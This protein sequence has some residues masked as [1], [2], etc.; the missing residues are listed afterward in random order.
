MSSLEERMQQLKAF[1]IEGSKEGE[2]DDPGLSSGNFEPL[3]FVA[4]FVSGTFYQ[5][6]TDLLDLNSDEHKDLTNTF[7]VRAKGQ[8]GHDYFF[9]D[10][11]A[12][13]EAY[14]RH[15]ALGG[16]TLPQVPRVYAFVFQ[17]DSGLSWSSEEAKNKWQQK[18]IIFDVPLRT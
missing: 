16:Q 13:S 4:P 17:R 6:Y 11:N 7:L 10:V 14:K 12:A 8:S 1:G 18:E 3:G 2:G 15:A 5:F 9:K